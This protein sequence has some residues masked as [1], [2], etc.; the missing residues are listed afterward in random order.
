MDDPELVGLIN[1]LEERL[2]KKF[3]TPAEIE[4]AGGN[5]LTKQL[6]PDYEDQ[7]A[8][9]ALRIGWSKNDDLS[10]LIAHADFKKDSAG[11]W[12]FEIYGH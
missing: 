2:D 5:P 11:R 9:G 4:R 3:C 1:A 6:P 10:K 8:Q 12:D 7:I